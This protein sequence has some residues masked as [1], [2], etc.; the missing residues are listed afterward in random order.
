MPSSTFRGSRLVQ[1]CPSP[2]KFEIIAGVSEAAVWSHLAA[3]DL[4]L[5]LRLVLVVDA[6]SVEHIGDHQFGLA[7]H[8][9]NAQTQSLDPENERSKA[10]AWR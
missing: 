6:H 4:P 7:P 1:A 9:G 10:F 5:E 8:L 2:P 3:F